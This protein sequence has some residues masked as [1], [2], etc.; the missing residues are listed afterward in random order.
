[1][2][3]IEIKNLI[4]TDDV[5]NSVRILA[6]K[7]AYALLLPEANNALRELL[8]KMKQYPWEPTWINAILHHV[9]INSAVHWDRLTTDRANT[10]VEIFAACEEAINEVAGV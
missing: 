4:E 8:L 1:M 2:T 9:V 10:E 7:K 3:A 5:A 6:L